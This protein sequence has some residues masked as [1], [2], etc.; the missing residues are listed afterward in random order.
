[1]PIAVRGPRGNLVPLGTSIFT[2][3]CFRPVIFPVPL[4]FGI[5]LVRRRSAPSRPLRQLQ[6]CDCPGKGVP[7]VRTIAPS[8][9]KLKRMASVAAVAVVAAI[10]SVAIAEARG[11][12]GGG[13]GG[14]VRA[15]GFSGGGARG[16]SAGGF[17]GFSGGGMR[18]SRF[19]GARALSGNRSA[20]FRS[21]SGV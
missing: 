10:V 3:L 7:T 11:H 2:S 5:V 6:F 17:R 16:F 21:G 1:W 4:F 13:G 9:S 18:S 8:N 15:G 19:S 14:G 20:M 12:G